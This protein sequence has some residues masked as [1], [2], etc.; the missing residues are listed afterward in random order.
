M[1]LET[2]VSKGHLGQDATW[3]VALAGLS[4]NL[5]GVAHFEGKTLTVSNAS[6][7]VAPNAVGGANRRC[8]VAVVQNNVTRELELIVDEVDNGAPGP[9]FTELGVKPVFMVLVAHVPVGLTNL[10]DS[11]VQLLQVEVPPNAPNP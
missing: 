11:H 6:H 7:T 5:N 3:T 1:A 9:N 2:K 4:F 8:R 10:A